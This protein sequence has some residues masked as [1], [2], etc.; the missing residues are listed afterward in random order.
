M[1]RDGLGE[2]GEGVLPAAWLSAEGGGGEPLAPWTAGAG[3]PAGAEC[4]LRNGMVGVAV[5]LHDVAVD[6]GG[7]RPASGRAG[8]ADRSKTDWL[9]GRWCETV[10]RHQRWCDAAGTGSGRRNEKATAGE[11]HGL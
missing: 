3:L 10:D 8:A 6:G 11:L 4:A 5:E 2:G 1:V 7:D 9:A